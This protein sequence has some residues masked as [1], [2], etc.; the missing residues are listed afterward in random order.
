[1]RVIARNR[2]RPEGRRPL[3]AWPE[4]PGDPH[5][6]PSGQP[7]QSNVCCWPYGRPCRAHYDHLTMPPPG[8]RRRRPSHRAQRQ[9][10][11]RVGE[12]V[13]AV[14]CRAADAVRRF[15]ADRQVSQGRT[16]GT[17]RCANA[18]SCAPRGSDM[19]V[20]RLL[21]WVLDHD[22]IRGLQTLVRHNGLDCNPLGRGAGEGGDHARRPCDP[23]LPCSR[24]NQ[25]HQIPTSFPCTAVRAWG[26]VPATGC[27]VPKTKRPPKGAGN[28]GRGSTP[29]GR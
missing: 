26:T 20:E 10:S 19:G 13:D 1:M 6:Q 22:D 15:L 7:Q 9:P 21:L 25:A 5:G 17:P 12:V 8:V 3:P 24:S 27:F 18:A 4:R 28:T 29:R 11:A 23:A 16:T 2:N 14:E